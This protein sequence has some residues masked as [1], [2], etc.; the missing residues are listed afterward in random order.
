MYYLTAE[1]SFDGAHFL[2]GYEGKCS[3]L[4]GHRW[5]V[6]LKIKTDA[7][8]NE[9]Q[10]RGMVVDFGDVKDA[11]KKEADF[12]DHT[13]IYEEGSLKETT[14]EALKSEEFLM[15][16]V[17]FRPTAENFSKYFYDKFTGYG[18]NVAEVT[19]YETPNNCAS[20]SE[21]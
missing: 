3:N 7:L 9:G 8:Q 14:V 20:Y 13:L 15:R 5:R 12:F 21:D 17:P 1:E 18:F 11:L 10:Q 4:H 16:V 6:I 19:V 2:A